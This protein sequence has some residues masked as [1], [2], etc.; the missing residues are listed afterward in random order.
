[1]GPQ[2]QFDDTAFAAA[3]SATLCLLLFGGSNRY[4]IYEIIVYAELFVH[5]L[6]DN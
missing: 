5:F 4:F 3:L 1:M 6:C 2:A